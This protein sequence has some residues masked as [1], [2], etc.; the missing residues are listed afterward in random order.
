MF[1]LRSG[2]VIA[3]RYR[4]DSEIG[5]GLFTRV[6]LANDLQ[7]A[8]H[9]VV[10][11]FLLPDSDRLFDAIGKAAAFTHSG[12][13]TILDRGVDEHPYV[14]TEY[15]PGGTLGDEIAAMGPLGSDRVAE[16][17]IDAC[18]V[19]TSAHESGL[20]HRGLKPSNILFDS[21]DQLKIADFG[22]SMGAD[23]VTLAPGFLL[24]YTAP[25]QGAGDPL[26]PA[27]D[28]F[29][30][31]VILAEAVSGGRVVARRSGIAVMGQGTYRPNREFICDGSLRDAI[32]RA[33]RLDPTER[34]QSVAEMAGSI[35]GLRAI[36]PAF[37]PAM[38]ALRHVGSADPAS[39]PAAAVGLLERPVG[40]ETTSDLAWPAEK[41]ASRIRPV[42]DATDVEDDL[43]E[44][45][46]PPVVA[47]EPKSRRRRRRWPLILVL[48][49]LLA[50]GAALVVPGVGKR[51]PDLLGLT[52]DG[53][54]TQSEA[55]GV[56]SDV[57]TT[58]PS[59][60]HAKGTVIGQSPPP[61]G[62]LGFRSP[63]LLTLSS[64][65]PPVAV[66]S[67]K[68]S[69]AQ[70]ASEALKQVG[71]VAVVIGTAHSAEE[72]GRV[73][74]QD[75][76]GSVAESG[77]SV[78]LTL[79]SGPEPAVL[80]D[81]ANKSAKDAESEL[82]GLRM[83]VTQTQENSDAVKAGSV[84]ST[85]PAP[86]TRVRSG[87]PVTVVVSKG[88]RMIPV[89]DVRGSRVTDATA[90]LQALG[91]TVKLVQIVGQDRVVAQDPPPGSSAK[92]GQTI[93]LT[94]GP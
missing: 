40:D 77:S 39:A 91:F 26:T 51:A 35:R 32:E 25:E 42:E 7:L 31:G 81:L 44:I 1:P 11:T 53:A 38:P 62:R 8:R 75:P 49:L 83:Q 19:L 29:A 27:T 48:M 67:V 85:S 92:K 10:K 12:A 78:L 82:L 94:T 13:L 16:V 73:L 2:D 54:R 55:S 66:P 15:C 45:F 3:N 64:G 36:P 34:F 79:S 70:Q 69:S 37:A 21:S 33:T 57:I 76:T 72:S 87:Y 24:A 58:V 52:L 89:P 74:S 41:P 43:D 17:A 60:L 30:L 71:L 63:V 65:P 47:D 6:F 4:L 88:P 9:V 84:I 28:V 90:K 18:A 23:D 80:P 22:L 61:N 50:G 46:E 86:G 68:G 56:R 5:A 14:V 20:L 93:T 59:A